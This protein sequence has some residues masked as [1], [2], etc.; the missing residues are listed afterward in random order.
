MRPSFCIFGLALAGRR[1]VAAVS[2][3][4]RSMPAANGFDRSTDLMMNLE[5]S[6]CFGI[7]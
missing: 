7:G 1:G 2:R 6:I 5:L 3:M 4:R